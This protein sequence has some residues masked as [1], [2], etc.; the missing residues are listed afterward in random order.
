MVSL[1][2]LRKITENSKNNKIIYT[3]I[4]FVL[5]NFMCQLNWAKAGNI[6]FLGVPVRVFLGEISI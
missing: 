3:H 4:I 1:F 6:F 2:S 5:G